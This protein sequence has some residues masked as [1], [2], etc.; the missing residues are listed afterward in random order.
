[1]QQVPGEQSTHGLRSQPEQHPVL[2]CTAL[3]EP[4]GRQGVG[5]Q[6]ILHMYR[7]YER[8]CLHRHTT[9]AEAAYTLVLWGGGDIPG[10]PEK[11]G[12]NMC[13][14][15]CAGGILLWSVLPS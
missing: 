9:E 4:A 2:A 5:L 14:A 8:S 6:D 15:I 11:E 12:T 3:G 13:V 1:M 7:S 10:L